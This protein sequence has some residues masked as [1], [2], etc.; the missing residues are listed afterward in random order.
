VQPG[1]SRISWV[2]PSVISK[3]KVQPALVYI[4]S[5]AG[6]LVALLVLFFTI[7]S[8]PTVLEAAYESCE[9]DASFGISLDD[10]GKGMFLDMKG[11]EDFIGADYADI[12]CILGELDVPSSV[13]S[14]ISNT[15]S[16]MGTQTAS[17]ENITASWTYHPDRGLDMK[18]ALD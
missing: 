18:L 5:A 6:G 13:I 10:D 16:L 17:W 11:E 14:Q 9:G 4:I 12:T 1:T 3:K 15:N 8:G 2:E 7:S